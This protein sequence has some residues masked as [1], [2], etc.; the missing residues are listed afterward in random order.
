MQKHGVPSRDLRHWLNILCSSVV[1]SAAS[2]TFEINKSFLCEE[3][4]FFN[5]DFVKLLAVC[6]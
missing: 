5:L 6:Q 2:H 3:C 4:M 1:T